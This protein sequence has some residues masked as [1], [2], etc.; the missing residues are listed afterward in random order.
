MKGAPPHQPA[1]R[2]RVSVHSRQGDDLVVK[3]HETTM[4]TSADDS[5]DAH[6]TSTSAINTHP[7]QIPRAWWFMLLCIRQLLGASAVAVIRTQGVF[8][9]KPV[10]LRHSLINAASAL[11]NEDF[12][13]RQYAVRSR[14][15]LWPPLAGPGLAEAPL[16]TAYFKFG[17]GLNATDRN[18]SRCENYVTAVAN[19]GPHDIILNMC[20]LV[21]AVVPRPDLTDELQ[22]ERAREHRN[23]NHVSIV[24][25][26]TYMIQQGSTRVD[27]CGNLTTA[28]NRYSVT[29][30]QAFLVV[31]E[32]AGAAP[33]QPRKNRCAWQASEVVPQTCRARLLAHLDGAVGNDNAYAA[34]T[35]EAIMLGDSTMW[36]L[37][38]YGSFQHTGRGCTAEGEIQIGAGR[39]V[40]IAKC[41]TSFGGG[42]RPCP[43][44]QP[45]CIGYIEGK[46]WGRCVRL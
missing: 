25:Q 21:L 29:D 24:H 34:P 41:A 15:Q 10:A 44:P 28:I 8:K 5:S 35:G 22:L 2:E 36:R 46:Q 1:P 11:T 7:K 16:P 26:L 23:P 6:A 39:E 30:L 19:P 42:D 12:F 4:V 3:L 9:E 37:W 43:K 18:E 40:A 32:L 27:V 17:L 45:R 38:H 14:L 13:S 33:C 31:I 20:Y